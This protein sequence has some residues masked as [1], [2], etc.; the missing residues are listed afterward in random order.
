MG[1]YYMGNGC[2]NCPKEFGYREKG[3]YLPIVLYLYNSKNKVPSQHTM[4]S[5]ESYI[6]K[7][8]CK[9]HLSPL[10]KAGRCMGPIFVNSE[11]LPG[12]LD[13]ASRSAQQ[14]LA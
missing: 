9:H 8:P 12:L 14:S 5:L 3:V 6:T 7:E 2:F 4:E 1:K 11:A 10:G 13:K